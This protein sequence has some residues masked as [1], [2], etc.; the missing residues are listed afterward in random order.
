MSV[1][2]LVAAAPGWVLRGDIDFS[3]GYGEAVD[4]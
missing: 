1:S 3:F 2:T 4:A